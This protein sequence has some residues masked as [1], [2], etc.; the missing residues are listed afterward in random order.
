MDEIKNGKGLVVSD[1]HLGQWRATGDRVLKVLNAEIDRERPSLL[2]LN[3][4]I[5]DGTHPRGEAPDIHDSIGKGVQKLRELTRHAIQAN[6]DAQIVY[7][8]GNHDSYLE[9]RDKL[10]RLSNEGGI[11]GHLHLEESHFRCRDAL[12]LHGDL[13]VEQG[14]KSH[15]LSNVLRGN[16]VVHPSAHT[17]RKEGKGISD[18]KTVSAHGFV[19]EAKVACISYFDNNLSPYVSPIKEYAESIID[20]FKQHEPEAIEGVRRVVIGHIHPPY[21]TVYRHPEGIEVL[22]T[23]ASTVG[24]RASI[25]RFTVGDKKL[26]DFELF[27]DRT[28]GTNG[29]AR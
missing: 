12:F 25:Y 18:W 27:T 8:F 4:D 20:H 10:E 26:S 13:Q 28:H 3:G 22:A 2:V 21:G 11:Q 7:V 1:L 14:S 29:H 6:P 23:G 15:V 9:I 17:A 24:S 19:K 16:R 5:I